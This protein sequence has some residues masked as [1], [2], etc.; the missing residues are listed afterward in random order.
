VVGI[1]HCDDKEHGMFGCAK[2]HSDCYSDWGAINYV[3]YTEDCDLCNSGQSITKMNIKDKE[4]TVVH[5]SYASVAR[6]FRKVI[7]DRNATGYHLFINKKI[8]KSPPLY[9]KK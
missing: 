8:N 6:A 3:C 1:L 9:I 4:V 5:G 2:Y 7:T